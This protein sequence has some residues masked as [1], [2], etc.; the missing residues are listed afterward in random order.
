MPARKNLLIIMAAFAVAILSGFISASTSEKRLEGASNAFLAKELARVIKALD[1]VRKPVTKEL[2]ATVDPQVP[3][4]LRPVVARGLVKSLPDGNWQWDRVLTRGEA[5]YH[6]A[7]LLEVLREEMINT[8]VLI[9]VESGFADIG[10]SHWLKDSLQ[11][12]GGTG[13]LNTISSDR[14][15]PERV[16]KEADVRK[17][18]SSLIEYL[19]SNCLLVVFNGKAGKVRSKGVF[20]QIELDGWR[21]S[22]NR[23]KWFSFDQESSFFPDFRHVKKQLVYFAHDSF[24]PTGSFEV[25][26]GVSSAGMIKIQKK[27]SDKQLHSDKSEEETPVIAAKKAENNASERQKLKDRLTELQGKYRG[28]QKTQAVEMLPAAG[29]I[30][31]TMP[32]SHLAPDKNMIIEETPSENQATTNVI[33]EHKRPVENQVAPDESAR[34][35][36]R[37]S[38]GVEPREEEF[39]GIIVDAVNGMPLKGAVVIIGSR[40]LAA[41]EKGCFSFMAGQSVVVD[42]TAYS[43]GY[44]ALSMRHRPGYR[45][46]PLKLSLKPVLTSFSGKIL[47]SESAIPVARVLVKIGTR[48]TRT[49]ADGHFA[50]KGIKPGYHQLSCFARGFME[51]H[52]IIHAG[53]EPVENF[54]VKIRPIFEEYS[55][56]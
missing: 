14:L 49:D 35:L 38:E 4:D 9:K 22:F 50:F 19:G 46:G 2:S 5:C 56:N 13:A 39:A 43:E 28:M 55:A 33:P 34:N 47:H 29:A 3:E 41:D 1:S 36:E 15:Y 51:A 42:V 12:L 6:F 17:I 20:Q 45:Q 30:S 7:R 26:E 27:F 44:E 37:V 21:Y 18:S 23:Q 32:V 48:A 24:L 8:P 52:E 53:N 40:Q 16:I 11:L 10:P 25:Q 31:K 54:E